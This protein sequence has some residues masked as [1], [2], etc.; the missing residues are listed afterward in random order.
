MSYTARSM[1]PSAVVGKSFVLSI[2]FLILVIALFFIPEI[3]QIQESLLSGG[4]ASRKA[5]SVSSYSVSEEAAR[6]SEIEKNKNLSSLDKVLSLINSGYLESKSK[7]SEITDRQSARARL[8]I[9]P[10][11]PALESGTAEGVEQGVTW[12][13]IRSSE[14]SKVLRKAK[15]DVRMLARSLSPDAF[16]SR[17]A[18]LNYQNGIGWLLEGD[19][20]PV[21][22]QQA[23]DYIERLD[24][25]VTRALIREGVD[26]ADYIRWSKI[27]LGPLFVNSKAR[28]LRQEYLSPFN[29]RI[30]LASVRLNI[31]KFKV[32]S[33]GSVIPPSS[34][35]RV[36]GFIMGKDTEKLTL[37][38][39]GHRVKKISLQRKVDDQGKRAFRFSVSPAT[40]AITVQ[41]IDGV[42]ASVQKTYKFIPRASS[43][44]R[45]SNRKV[46]L[47]FNNVLSS[48]KFDLK[49][50]DLRLDRFFRDSVSYAPSPEQQRAQAERYQLVPF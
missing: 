19:K 45:T 40:G 42:N 25:D 36:V 31:G 21:T 13:I 11:A 6:L 18:L 15:D 48:R 27:S 1:F 32:R 39:N 49:E 35:L 37:L 16:Q 38:R 20:S 26:R 12:K 3:I 44:P 30:T 47:P 46:L 29:P 33:D 9:P 23:L 14:V 2:L 8:N 7:G 43:F 5:V 22:V 34:S 28:R 24:L 4:S 50:V 41:A 17:E 10:G